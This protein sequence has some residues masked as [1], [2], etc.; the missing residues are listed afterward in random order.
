MS[1]STAPLIPGTAPLSVV[2]QN[3]QADQAPGSSGHITPQ[4]ATQSGPPE[5]ELPTFRSQK[6]AELWMI[7]ARP[8]AD[9]IVVA[10]TWM[11]LIYSGGD[12]PSVTSKSK[13]GGRSPGPNNP[14]FE[15]HRFACATGS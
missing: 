11:A 14:I 7:G 15:R 2:C 5:N 9:W 1:P 8:M 4:F 3:V 12:R 10:Q 13:A 6:L